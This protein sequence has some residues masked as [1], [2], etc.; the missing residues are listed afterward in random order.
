MATLYITEV[1]EL[2]VANFGKDIAAPKM[3]PE[4]EQTVAIGGAS[5]QSNAFAPTTHFIIVHSDAI[6]SLAFGANPT[7]AGSAHRLAANETRF[8][9]VNA[10]DKVAAITNT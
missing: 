7:A 2:G 9:G 6:C 5:T 3:P 8:Y 10:G 4:A 1:K